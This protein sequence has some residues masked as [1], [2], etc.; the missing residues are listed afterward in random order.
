LNLVTRPTIDTT[1]APDDAP[2]LR[3]SKQATSITDTP[4]RHATETQRL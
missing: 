1:T 3:E 4:L 2:I